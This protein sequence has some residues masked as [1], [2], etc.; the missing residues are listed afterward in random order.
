MQGLPKKPIIIAAIVIA[1]LGIGTGAVAI[2]RAVTPS[3]DDNTP[4][5]NNSQAVATKVVCKDDVIEKGDRLIFESSGNE[6]K[7]EQ[8]YTLATSV[9]GLKDYTQ[10]PNCLYIVLSAAIRQSDPVA[11]RTYYDLLSQQIR[12][13]SRLS[14]LFERSSPRI[15]SLK[16]D[17][18][19]LEENDAAS[20]END[21]VSEDFYRALDE[22]DKRNNNYEE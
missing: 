16:G 15:D 14:G 6:G 9:Q 7:A 3:T 11:S 10:D 12:S 5:G 19:I 20:V 18:E 21:A 2:W 4:Q 1:V 22:I 13:G 8:L 17:V